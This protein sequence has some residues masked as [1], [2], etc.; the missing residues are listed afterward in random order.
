MAK[1]RVFFEDGIVTG[2]FTDDPRSEIEIV[3]FDRD[4]D[5]KEELEK[6]WDE[7]QKNLKSVMP[8]ITHP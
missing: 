6:I 8:V 2:A 4:L 5:S 3:Q 1:L 7:S